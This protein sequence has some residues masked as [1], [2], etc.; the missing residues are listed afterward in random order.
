[1]N[2][3]TSSAVSLL[4]TSSADV[5]SQAF[6][7]A[8]ESIRQDIS[9]LTVRLEQANH[10]A[11][12]GQLARFSATDEAMKMSD[13]AVRLRCDR[14][15]ATLV[16][17]FE[18]QLRF[19]AQTKSAGVE[20]V[21]EE[22]SALVTSGDNDSVRARE[23]RQRMMAIGRVNEK[24]MALLVSNESTLDSLDALSRE[25]SGDRSLTVFDTA[26]SG[27]NAAA[28]SVDDAIPVEPR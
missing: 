4:L 21:R 19:M 9:G 25:E 11:G 10:Q 5:D 7:D 8:R 1:M 26:L 6:A 13:D 22:L 18:R 28:A 20:E 27:A 16:S 17:G 2:S 15:L 14:A 24:I 23:L 3:S 12:L